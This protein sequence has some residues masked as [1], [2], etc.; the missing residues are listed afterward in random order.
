V[1]IIASCNG[2]DKIAAQSDEEPVF[3]IQVERNWADLKTDVNSGVVSV[4][5][6]FAA[7]PAECELEQR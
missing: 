6:A 5:T 7:R 3:A 2:I 1:A 4:F